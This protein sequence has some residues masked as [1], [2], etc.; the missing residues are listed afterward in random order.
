MIC[1]VVAMIR[2]YRIDK[3]TSD[4]LCDVLYLVSPPFLSLVEGRTTRCQPKWH[5]YKTYILHRQVPAH[6]MCRVWFR[7][8]LSR[9]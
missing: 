3:P 1:G 7:H 2:V 6:I 9:I 4:R 5:T 8:F